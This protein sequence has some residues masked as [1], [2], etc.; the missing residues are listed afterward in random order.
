MDAAAAQGLDRA[1]WRHLYRRALLRP[2]LTVTA[3]VLLYYALPLD[4]PRGLPLI[5]TFTAGFVVLVGL[6]V[7]QVSAILRSP[8]PAVQAVEAVAV[9]IPLFLLLFAA[10]YHVTSITSP[11]TFTQQMS[12][13]SALYFTV[14]VFATV[15]FGDITPVTEAARAL[16]LIQMVADLLILG[17]LVQ[18]FTRAVHLGRARRSN[19][20][21]A[22]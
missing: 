16:V 5:V 2:L 10:T 22:D 12:K 15:G 8:Y 11:D 17:V 1:T 6:T 7:W 20:S 4:R 21:A 18:V 13:T 9:A 19:A 14:T 3:L